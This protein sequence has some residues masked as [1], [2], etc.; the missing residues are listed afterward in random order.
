VSLDL[1]GHVADQT[2]EKEELASSVVLEEG[3][4]AE[5]AGVILVRHE[6]FAL[7]PDVRKT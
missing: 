4:T 6:L 2:D 3:G 1:N 7:S 5:K